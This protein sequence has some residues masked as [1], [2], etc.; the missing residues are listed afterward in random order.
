ML[1]AEH[2]KGHPVY[3]DRVLLNQSPES[4]DVSPGGPSDEPSISGAAPSVEI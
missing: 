4:F 3:E 2:A 1:S